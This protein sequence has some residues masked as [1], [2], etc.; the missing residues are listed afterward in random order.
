VVQSY[1]V[2]FRYC[3][4]LDCDREIC[5]VSERQERALVH[6]ITMSPMRSPTSRRPHGHRKV[7]QNFLSSKHFDTKYFKI[8]CFVTKLQTCDIPQIF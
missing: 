8:N 5:E 1:Y 3:C 4:I 6:A 7:N 2:A